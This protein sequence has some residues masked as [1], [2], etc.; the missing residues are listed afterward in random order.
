MKKWNVKLLGFS[1][2]SS[3]IRQTIGSF[4]FYCLPHLHL[5]WGVHES[6]L[7]AIILYLKEL[8]N[9]IIKKETNNHWTRA[10]FCLSDCKGSPSC[11]YSSQGSIYRWVQGLGYFRV[12]SLCSLWTMEAQGGG[13]SVPG[14]KC[15]GTEFAHQKHLHYNN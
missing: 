6:A 15:H 4:H 2:T 9:L 10:Q 3:F 1:I 7:F 12:C 5:F 11:T 13:L 14:I 8:E